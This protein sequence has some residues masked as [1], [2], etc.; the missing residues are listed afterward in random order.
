[1]TTN[2]WNNAFDVLDADG[3]L[4]ADQGIPLL[5]VSD[6]EFEVGA[7]LYYRGDT[8]LDSSFDDAVRTLPLNRARR[9]DLASVPAALR[10]FERPHGIHTPAALFHDYLL[11]HGPD[12]R[13]ADASVQPQQ[14]DL[15]FRFMLKDLGVPTVKRYLL[16]TAVAL[17]TRWV[18]S[19]L[20]LIVWTLLSVTGLGLFVAALAGVGLP[21]WIGS[22]WVV[23]AVTGVAPLPASLLWGRERRAALVAAVMAIWILP[24][25]AIAM[26]ALAV[27]GLLERLVGVARGS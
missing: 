5:Q 26:I 7:T 22:R 14:A 24:A 18:T 23:L 10:W 3:G 13:V 19:R 27:Y 21:D 15:L 12:L 6:N 1:M 2:P 9:S 20:S 4:S 8:G 25:G 17:R 11:V 16:W